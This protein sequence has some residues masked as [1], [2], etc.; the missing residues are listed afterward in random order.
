MGALRRGACAVLLMAGV[1]HLP[2]APLAPGEAF[3]DL[4]AFALEGSVPDTSQSRVVIVDFWASWC[5]PCRAAFPVLD[6]IQGEFGPRGVQVIAV[7]VDQNRGAMEMFLKKRPVSFAVVRDA[8]MKLVGRV[9]VPTMPTTFVLDASGRVR[10][11]HSGFRG[12]ETRAQL[13]EQ[14]TR[15]LEEKS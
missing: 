11:M 9:D 13:R 5:T 3:P 12:E 6:E 15:L 14:I 1:A 2:G 10:F 7:S 8:A 4:E